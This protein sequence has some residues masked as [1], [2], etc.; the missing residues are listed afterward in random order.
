MN[1]N[2]PRMNGGR[3]SHSH[4]NGYNAGYTNTYNQNNNHHHDRA[5]SNAPPQQGRARSNS[6]NNRQR[7]VTV[8]TFWGD[9]SR[10]KS[11]AQ[12][13]EMSNKAPSHWNKQPPPSHNRGNLVN[14]KNGKMATPQADAIR[15]SGGRRRTASGNQASIPKPN[16]DENSGT[17]HQKEVF[18]PHHIHVAEVGFILFYF[19]CHTVSPRA[20]PFYLL[21]IITM[22]SHHDTIQIT[23]SSIEIVD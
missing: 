4:S 10:S 18:T 5:S 17:P 6:R 1:Q 7:C 19:I 15:N 9:V 23:I 20:H 3:L 21:S 22:K 11:E 13:Y 16:F 14:S 2:S 8:R 12:P